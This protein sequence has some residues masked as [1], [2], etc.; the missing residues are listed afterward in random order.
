MWSS[1]LYDDW[2]LRPFYI[3]SSSVAY[4]SSRTAEPHQVR[5][6]KDNE[7]VSVILDNPI[8]T[9]I[10]STTVQ[11]QAEVRTYKSDARRGFIFGTS[12][13][14]T[15]DNAILVEAGEGAGI[16]QSELSGLLPLTKY[17]V[18]AF[19]STENETIYSD[20][21]SFR[22]IAPDEDVNLSAEGTSN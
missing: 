9:D 21:L 8:L 6:I 5:C 2:Q 3:S 11:I 19:V 16:F 1:S 20:K 14:L 10:S 22:T 18:M 13:D 17:Y 7:T 12:E 4:S 15:L